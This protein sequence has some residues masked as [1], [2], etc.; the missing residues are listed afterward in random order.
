MVQSKEQRMKEPTKRIGKKKKNCKLCSR[1]PEK[2]LNKE[3]KK[4]GSTW[5]AK[6]PLKEK[7]NEKRKNVNVN[8]LWG[9]GWGR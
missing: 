1:S 2:D 4:R 9:K 8:L 6:N 3:K 5:G 7:E